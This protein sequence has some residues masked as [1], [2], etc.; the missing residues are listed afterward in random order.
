MTESEPGVA[1]PTLAVFGDVDVNLIDGSSIWLVSLCSVLDRID[2]RGHVLLKAPIVRDV[3]SRELGLLEHF[4][5]WQ[6]NDVEAGDRIGPGDLVDAL[7]HIDTL[8]RLDIVIV[9]G[10]RATT[11]LVE[12][13]HFDGRLWPYLTDIPQVADD[14]TDDRHKQLQRVF[15]VSERVLCQTESLRSFLVSWFPDEDA[16]MLLLP[17]MV[18][19]SAFQDHT[20]QPDS[21][22]LKLF[23]AGKFAPL[24]GIEEMLSAVDSVRIDHPG[25]GITVAGDKIHNP[26]DDPTYRDRID[27]ALAA[28]G[29]DW[30]GGIDRYRV[31]A[32][33]NDIDMAVSVRDER[34]DLSRELSTKLLEYAASGVPAIVNRTLAHEGLLGDDYPLFVDRPSEIADRI[35]DVLDDVEILAEASAGLAKVAAPHSMDAIAKMMEPALRSSIAWGRSEMRGRRI[36]VASH[37]FKFAT[38]L[39]DGLRAAGAE[40]RLDDWAWGGPLDE[41]R[42]L[43]LLDWADTVVCEWCLANAVWYSRHRKP[44]QRLVVRFHRSE[45]LSPWPSEV[46]FDKVDAVV[47]VGSHVRDEAQEEF[48]WG[49]ERLTVIPNSVDTVAFD[50][51][52]L[53]GARFTLGMLGYLPRLKRI[54]RALDI[55]ETLRAV[56]PRYRL[57]LKGSPPWSTDWVWIRDAERAYYET[58]FERIRSSTLLRESVTFDR[59]GADV[60]SWFRKIGF[61]LSLSDTESFHLAL[62]EGMSARSVPI[63]TSRPGASSIVDKRWIIDDGAGAVQ[64]IVGAASDPNSVLGEEARDEAVS[65]YRLERTAAI[66]TDLLR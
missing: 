14:M 58:Q 51:P 40:V 46:A 33:L 36:V 31:F 26:A 11:E 13:G 61:I 41:G 10:L 24:W 29:V 4:R 39:I 59:P 18:P 48:G 5:V 7:V 19:D 55:L 62:I 47:F 45:L 20:R 8:D 32:A 6:P 42:S 30:L 37:A 1:T 66:W 50:R 34:L 35:N 21:D 64:R 44:D 28:D 12:S 65:R 60:P 17:P 54:D 9:R 49:E 43:E 63:V 27:S 56:D 15:S 25:L 57:I 23:Y 22:D 3:L 16:K 38:E 53:P 52:K 2:L